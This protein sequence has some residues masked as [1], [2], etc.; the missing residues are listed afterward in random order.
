MLTDHTFRYIGVRPPNDDTG[1]FQVT[2]NNNDRGS[3]RVPSLRNVELRG[4]FFHNGQFTTLEQVVAF[5]NR[6]GDF[7][8]PNK[9]NQL[10]RPLGLNAGQ[11]ADLV[12]FLRRPLTDP[13]V[14]A[15]APPFDKP[16]LYMG[17][18]RMP[19][20]TGTGRAGS[21]NFTPQIR[22]I[23]PPLAG[24]PNFTVSVSAAIGN[25]SA[26]LVIDS[27]DPGVGTSIPASGSFARVTANT[28]NTGAGN[29]WVSVSLPIPDNAAIV[30]QTFFARWYVPDAGAANGFS[31]SQAARFTV[32]GEAS[33]PGRGTFVDFDGDGKT[34]ISVFRPEEG[35]W[36]ILKSSDNSFSGVH[37]GISTDKLAPADYDGDRKT[38]VAVFRDGIW[39]LS[40]SRD[41]L[42]VQQFG[43][44]GDI[45]QPGDYDGDGIDDLAVYRPSDGTWYMQK[46][47][48]GFAA[49]NFGIASDKPISG[50]FD[51]DGRTDQ[52][53][54]RVGTW[55]VLKS[56]GGVFVTQYGLADDKPVVGDYDGD[57]KADIAVWRPSNGTWYRILSDNNADIATNFGLNGDTPSPGDYDGD[58]ANDLTVYRPSE[59]IW[60][61]Q[62]ST[63][64]SR[65]IRFG[66]QHDQPIPSAI[67]P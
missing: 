54:Y 31:V 20:I 14:A 32:F 33:A 42:L 58:G 64:G 23:S 50:D 59:G 47:R 9:P 57:G 35:N 53:V 46:S 39:Y 26:V 7:N 22:A 37:F 27:A 15:E 62:N 5:Y 13:R 30:G 44:S 55:Y 41:G 18:G 65:A 17:S 3:F 56:T 16:A 45:A 29:G 21:G 51:G 24:N 12:G 2:G 66:L 40:R 6:G 61:L 34:D 48:D 10:I 1:R 36:Y 8:A 11:Q 67:V 19:Q 38:D 28:Q 25:S 4:S 49:E 60:Y 52:A 63:S 43:L